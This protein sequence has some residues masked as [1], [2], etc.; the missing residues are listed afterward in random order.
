MRKIWIPGLI[1]IISIFLNS[2]SDEPTKPSQGCNYSIDS[3]LAGLYECPPNENDCFEGVLSNTEKLKALN[4]LN[5]IR[6][7]HGLPEVTYNSLKDVAVQKSALIAVANQVLTHFPEPSSKCYTTLGDTACQQS[8][9]H[10]SYYSSLGQV[11]SSAESV[12]GWINER[13]SSSIGHRRWFLSPFLKSVSFGRV[14]Q[15]KTNGQY[16]VASSMWVWDSDGSTDANVEFIA[17]PFHDYPKSAFDKDLI[18]SFSVLMNKTNWWSN[19]KVNFS[20]S[21]IQI[22]DE[23]QTN[24]SV[25]DILYDTQNYGLPNNLQ[26]KV[27]GLDYNKRYNVTITNV[28]VNGQIKNYDYW[29]K[30]IN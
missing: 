23:S 14:D 29:F 1:I 30:I 18:L 13:Y 27:T 21:S 4:R 7:I 10:L 11:W 8:N 17:C 2:C 26:W 6:G 25:S 20:N 3:R 9:L 15:I 12:D 22:K 28:N 16:W 19:N 24:Y 5:Y